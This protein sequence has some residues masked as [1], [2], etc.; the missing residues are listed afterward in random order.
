M[1]SIELSE[2]I[3]ISNE[4]LNVSELFPHDEVVI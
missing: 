4:L 3:T 2:N 1:Y